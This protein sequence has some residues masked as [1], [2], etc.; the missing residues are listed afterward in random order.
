MNTLFF[1]NIRKYDNYFYYNFI[2]I[3]NYHTMIGMKDSLRIENVVMLILITGLFW[4]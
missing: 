4:L 2:K 1:E 3:I